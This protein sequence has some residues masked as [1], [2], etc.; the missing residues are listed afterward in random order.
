[1]PVSTAGNDLAR[2][3]P[4]IVASGYLN[5]ISQYGV[6]IVTTLTILYVTMGLTLRIIEFRRE[7]KGKVA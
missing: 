6:A 2:A 7:L 5:F 4:L 3:A 1:M